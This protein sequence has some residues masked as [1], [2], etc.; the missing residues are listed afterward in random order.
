M[1]KLIEEWREFALDYPATSFAIKYALTV[2]I[3]LPL[4]VLVWYLIL[5]AIH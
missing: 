4:M 2:Y 5:V 3:G 1:K